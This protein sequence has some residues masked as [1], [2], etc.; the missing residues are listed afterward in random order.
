VSR[1][2]NVSMTFVNGYQ[3]EQ[4]DM[5]DE[6]DK[7]RSGSIAIGIRVAARL[8][9]QLNVCGA[10]SLSSF[11]RGLGDNVKLY[12]LRTVMRAVSMIGETCQRP[13]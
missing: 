5:I 4:S 7:N 1:A 8:F 12:D 2:Y 11:R 13:R 6:T 9:P 10:M 3:L